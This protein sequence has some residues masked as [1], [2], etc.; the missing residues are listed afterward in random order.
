[1][2]EIDQMSIK[3]NTKSYIID[4]DLINFQELKSNRI[5]GEGEG[6]GKENTLLLILKFAHQ[7]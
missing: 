7:L 1:M 5:R 2:N 3:I 6:D 4:K